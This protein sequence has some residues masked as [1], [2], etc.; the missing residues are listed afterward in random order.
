MTTSLKNKADNVAPSRWCRLSVVG[1]AI[2]RSKTTKLTRRRV[3]VLSLEHNLPPLGSSNSQQV[4]HSLSTSTDTHCD[5]ELLPTIKHTPGIV[6]PRVPCS[7]NT[8]HS[9]HHSGPIAHPSSHRQC[10]FGT[11]SLHSYLRD[12][13]QWRLITSVINLGNHPHLALRFDHSS[14]N[15]IV[16]RH[17][18]HRLLTQFTSDAITGIG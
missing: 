17:C 5:F 13:N 3:T 4:T 14:L 15:N 6:H 12:C 10:G 16:F 7:L 18:L 9:S 8:Q 1:I 11:G 2:G